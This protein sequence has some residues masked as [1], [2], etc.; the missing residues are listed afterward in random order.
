HHPS[1]RPLAINLSST[2]PHEC[3]SIQSLGL[4]AKRA[5]QPSPRERTRRSPPLARS[6]K[7]K[8]LYQGIILREA[9]SLES[10]SLSATSPS[11]DRSM[12]SFRILVPALKQCKG[13]RCGRTKHHR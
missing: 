11:C 4:D 13:V 1:L 2:Q 8:C 6:A 3:D 12:S 7:T 9:K 10:S 5:T